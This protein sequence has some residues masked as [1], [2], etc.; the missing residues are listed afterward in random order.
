MDSIYVNG[1]DMG[2]S[3]KQ[4][5]TAIAFIHLLHETINAC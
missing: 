1:I 3:D 2:T 5:A 4:N